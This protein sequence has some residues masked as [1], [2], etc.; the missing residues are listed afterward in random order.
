MP[1]VDRRPR[2]RLPVE[3]R[4]AAITAAAGAAFAGAPY[5]KVSLAAIAETAGSSEA[6]VHRYFATKADLYEEIV[7]HAAADLSERLDRADEAVGGDDAPPW[8][9]VAMA[10]DAY[11]DFVAESTEGWAA[12]LRTPDQGFTP[13]NAIRLEARQQLATHLRAALSTPDGPPRD[14]ALFGFLGFLDAACLAWTEGGVPPEHRS[15]LITMSLGALSGAL[16]ALDA[17]DD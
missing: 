12:P 4:R 8:Q 7:G 5:D 17:D 9:R 15:A 2:R 14:Y 1:R 6:L 13:A 3:Q 11:L 16:G 10:I